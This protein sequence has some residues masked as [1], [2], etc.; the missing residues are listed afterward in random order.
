MGR[1]KGFMAYLGYKDL[2][3]WQKAMLLVEEVY[4]LT[5]CLPD[6][7]KFG[8]V[9]QMRRSAVSVPS[10]IAEGKCRATR[11]D[12]ARFIYT[13]IGSLAELE[14]QIIICA[15]LGYFKGDLKALFLIS[16]LEKMLGKLVIKLRSPYGNLPT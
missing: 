6:S 11:K 7:E 10:N 3:V 13:A 1:W 5:N 12:Y 4:R 15:R 8:L 2:Q 9:S 14:T 16:E